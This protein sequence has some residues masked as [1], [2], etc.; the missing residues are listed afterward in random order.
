VI[1]RLLIQ[2]VEPQK[3]AHPLVQRLLI[4]R[5]TQGG[6]VRI[7]RGHLSQIVKDA[8]VAE[9]P[10]FST[11]L[12]VIE[13]LIGV[14]ACEAKVYISSRKVQGGEHTATELS[15]DGGECIGAPVDA[16]THAGR[17]SASRDST[18]S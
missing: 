14:I 18:S 16:P 15:R 9:N 7:G 11:H 6:G 17:S 1:E 2:E 13:R 5:T 10:F 4:N 3:G 8:R 12:G